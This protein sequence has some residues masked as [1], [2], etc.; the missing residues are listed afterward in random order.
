MAIPTLLVVS[1]ISFT[2]MRYDVT[3]PAMYIPLGPTHYVGLL[4]SVQIKNPI[5][6]LA[7]LKQNPA[8]SK[9]AYQQEVE[10]LGLDK[11]FVVQYGLW[12]KNMVSLPPDLGLS[13]SGEKVSSL[14]MQRLPNTILLNVIVLVLTWAIALPMGVYAAVHWRSKADNLMAFLSSL[15]MGLPTFI[16]A[17]LLALICVKTRILP[18][19]GLTGENFDELNFFG[20]AW[21]LGLHLALPVIVLTLSSLAGLQRQMRGNLLE[22]LGANYIR[23]ARAKG[24]PERQVIYK[25]A[26]RCAINPMVTLLGF[27]FASLF[28]GAALVEMILRYPGIGSLALEAVRQTDTNLSMVVLTLGALVL[29]LGNLLADILLRFA[30]PRIASEGY[31]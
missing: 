23:T 29:I 8:I 1:F 7:E 9:A 4:H 6:P 30:D 27:E 16:M 18:V 5:N 2:I 14:V 26:L 28:S 15:S 13:F 11:P 25:H 19:G 20:K 21:D 10:R 12:L 22:V 3:I 17:L 31:S 24:L